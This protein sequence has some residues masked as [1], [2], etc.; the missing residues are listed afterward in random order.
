MYINIGII[1]LIVGI[2]V[3]CCYIFTGF[4]INFSFALGI[5]AA[6]LALVI[7]WLFWKNRYSEV[8]DYLQSLY[9]QVDQI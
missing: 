3:I 6:F 4:L 2:N 9:E 8:R 5:A 7:M 1:I